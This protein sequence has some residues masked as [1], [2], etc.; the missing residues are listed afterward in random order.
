MR[1]DSVPHVESWVGSYSLD[2]LLS[3]TDCTPRL[4]EIY[5]DANLRKEV[6]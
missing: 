1:F 6:Q 4:R 5:M 3:T 2:V